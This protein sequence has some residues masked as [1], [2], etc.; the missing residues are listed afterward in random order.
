M[1]ESA[2]TDANPLTM[3]QIS[4]TVNLAATLNVTHITNDVQWD[5]PAYFGQWASAIHATGL[6]MWVRG[7]PS[8]WED[9]YGTTGIMTP[10]AYESAMQAFLLDNI[11]D[12]QNG[13]IFDP[14]S[15]PE[16]GNYWIATYGSSY[17]N[18]APNAA[19]DDY[20]SFLISI[21]SEANAIFAAAGLSGVIT[22][23]HST[24]EWWASHPAAL[25][26][27]TVDNWHSDL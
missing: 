20:N 11:A 27:S 16:N 15:E 14:C 25:Y 3:A 13:D 8:Q 5:Y 2:D 23:V 21:T 10:A 26:A 18:G 6:H 12:F 24:N 19:T 7:H 17:T 1:K 9:S 4:D 22:T